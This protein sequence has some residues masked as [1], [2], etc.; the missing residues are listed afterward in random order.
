[1]REVKIMKVDVVDDKR[2]R[3]IDVVAEEAPLHVFID[4]TRVVSFL[5]SPNKLKELAV[6]FLFSEGFLRGLSE[7]HEVRLEDN[8][9]CLVTLK[10]AVDV[11]K[12][13]ELVQPFGRLVISACDSADLWPFAKL[14][15]RIKGLRVK[16][17]AVVRAK[18]IAE[19]VG[20]LSGLAEMYRRTGG[21]HVASLN[22][23]DGSLVASA[24]DVGRHNAVDKVIGEGVLVGA[25]FEQCF[26]ALSGR[27]SWD[28]VLKCARAGIPVVASRGAALSGGIEVARRCGVGLVGFVRAN[29]MNVYACP[30]RVKL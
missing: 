13:L 18:V 2:E 14:V 1:M 28:V 17:D 19:C 4:H 26:L 29:K 25:D 24:E 16:S 7:V 5:C 9:R 15:D 8:S 20:R 30:E 3:R 23:V 21:V 10:S 22:K 27:L 11:E 6:G 12:R